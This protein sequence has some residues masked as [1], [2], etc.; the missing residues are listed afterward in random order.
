MKRVLEDLMA[1]FKCYS[2]ERNERRESYGVSAGQTLP[3]C[4]KHGRGVK[5]ISVAASNLALL[6]GEHDLRKY[7]LV[8]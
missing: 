5:V 1:F 7:P 4:N 2:I 3:M 8:H 6:T